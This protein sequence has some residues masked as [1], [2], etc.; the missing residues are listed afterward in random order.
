MLI[1]LMAET[2]LIAVKIHDSSKGGWCDSG[3]DDDIKGG[4]D[5]DG[6]SNNGTDGHKY[7]SDDDGC[8]N[9]VKNCFRNK[10]IIL[11]NFSL[12]DPAKRKSL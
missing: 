6:E 9:S 2:K 5:S 4:D 1:V 11:E 8:L 7:D 12:P 10:Q 3:K